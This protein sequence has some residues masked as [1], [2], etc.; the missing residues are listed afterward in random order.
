MRDLADGED[1]DQIEEQL[2]RRD[3]RALAAVAQR[4][5]ALAPEPGFE[6]VEERTQDAGVSFPL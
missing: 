4:V 1:V 6:L 3:L 5:H 2:E